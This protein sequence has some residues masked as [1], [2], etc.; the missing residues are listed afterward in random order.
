MLYIP[1]HLTRCTFKILQVI[2]ILQEEI[3]DEMNDER[4]QRQTHINVSE[5]YTELG[6]LPILQGI[7]T[8]VMLNKF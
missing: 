8:L 2:A 1:F 7:L 3:R 6:V 5:G 4:G